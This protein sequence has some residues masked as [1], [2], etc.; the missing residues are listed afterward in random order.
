M[1]KKS[2]EIIKTGR[3]RLIATLEGLTTEQLNHIPEGYNNNMIWQLGHVIAVQQG[4]TYP[5][6][7]LTPVIDEALMAQYGNGTKPETVLDAKAIAEMHALSARTLEQFEK[8]LAND[9]FRNYDSWS[10]PNGMTFDSIEDALQ[11]LA[12]HE[13][14]HYGYAQALKRAVLQ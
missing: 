13:G 3:N 5:K 11:M 12:F 7:K 1:A 4:V 14:M 6:A 8:D 2:I 10:F 9:L